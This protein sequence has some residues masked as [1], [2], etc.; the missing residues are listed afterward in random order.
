MKMK[1]ALPVAD[2][3]FAKHMTERGFEVD[4]L[5]RALTHASNF[6][7]A[8]DGGAHVGSWSVAMA[9]RFGMVY[10]FEPSRDTFDCLVRNIGVASNIRACNLALGASR[11]RGTMQDDPSRPGNTGARYMGAGSDFEI[12]PVDDYGLDDL[13]LLKLD[14]EGAEYFAL[15][16]AADT[17]A[18]CRPVVVIERK[19]FKG[20][21]GVTIDQAG[22]LLRKF[23]MRE[24]DRIRN[25]CV[26]TF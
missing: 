18:R 6:R 22:D 13:D 3:Y 25:D 5:D 10:A 12:V 16:G 14:V 15:L 26:F 21:F 19:D 7:T 24:V 17:I 20:R 9:Q 2:T 8:I 11:L 1:W 4:H 23:G